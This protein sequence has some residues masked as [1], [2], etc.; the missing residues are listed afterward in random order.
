MRWLASRRNAS[1]VA[2]EA[3]MPD[4]PFSP[5]SSVMPHCSA[6]TRTT[7]SERWVLRLSHITCHVAADPAVANK[8]SRNVVVGLGAAVAN[9]AE[10]LAGGDIERRDQTLGTMPDILELPPFDMSRLHRQGRRGTLQ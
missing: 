5:R 8:P 7:P 3:R 10:D 4:L 6:T 2:I 9:G 1:R